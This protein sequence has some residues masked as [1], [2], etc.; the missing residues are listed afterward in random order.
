MMEWFA[1]LGLLFLCILLFRFYILWIVAKEDK[2]KEIID[3]GQYIGYGHVNTEEGKKVLRKI[4]SDPETRKFAEERRNAYK[5]E[6]QKK[7]ELERKKKVIRRT[8]SYQYE[9]ILFEIFAPYA[10]KMK[11][12]IKGQKWEIRI[13]QTLPNDF[14]I[15]EISRL[16]GI[17][18]EKANELFMEFE[19]NNML[20]INTI[21]T[22][23]KWRKGDRCSL[24]GLLLY[25][26]NIIS[27][28]D[29]NLTKW[30]EQHPDRE[31]KESVDLRRGVIKEHLTFDEYVKRE[32]GYSVE[33]GFQTLKIKVN[34]GHE[35]YLNVSQTGKNLMDYRNMPFGGIESIRDKLFVDIDDDRHTLYV[36]QK[37]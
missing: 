8:F 12:E 17:S 16:L 18:L 24:G 13:G 32:G 34:N 9:N 11:Y 21:Y 27:N 31:S 7:E 4:L 30:I 36:E 3:L 35:F 6:E 19:K 15:S 5:L 29:M 25:D 37:S 26:W 2:D 1:G 20:S 33:C 10:T 23:Q 28:E 22:Y 14:V